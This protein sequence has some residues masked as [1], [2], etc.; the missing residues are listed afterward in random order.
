MTP[1]EEAE[2]EYC[3]TRCGLQRCGY[4]ETEGKFGKP[5]DFLI[6]YLEDFVGAV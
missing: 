1:V 5:C 4:G 3:T 6:R 2:R